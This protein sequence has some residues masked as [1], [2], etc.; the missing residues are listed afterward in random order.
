MPKTKKI[1]L[2]KCIATNEQFPK[3]EMFRIVRDAEGNITI[4]E[5]GKARGRG[6]YISK[7]KRAIQLAMKKDS[8]S[9]HLEVSVPNTIYQELLL[10]LENDAKPKN[11]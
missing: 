10:L 9:K 11:P 6:A 8:L 4:D 3:Q 7:S 5:N 2:R 1:P